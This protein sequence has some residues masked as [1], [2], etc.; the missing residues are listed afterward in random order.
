M[1][2]PGQ[3]GAPGLFT[4]EFTVLTLAAALGFCNIA[5]FYG[6]ATWLERMGV[7]PA[8]RGALIAAEPLAALAARPL[9]SFLLTARR[10]LFTARLG[11]LGMGLAL[12]CYQLAHTAPA[13]FA[14]RVFHGLSFV[15]LVSA[16]MALL[17]KVVPPG[18]AG[19][20]FGYFS[21]SSLI[22]YAVMPP[23]MEWLLP[24]VGGEARAYAWTALLTLPALALMAPLGA[25]LGPGAFPD[26]EDRRG[27]TPGEILENLR[28]GPVLLL[29]GANLLVFCA[30]TQV[31]FFIKPYAV[32][33]RLAEPGLFFTVSTCAS[34]AVRVLG[35]PYFDRLPRRGAALAALAALAACVGLFAW[36]RGA[37]AFFVL[38]GAYGL[39][40]G[41]ALPLLNASL[42]LESAPRF[43][44]ANMN[45]ML[46]MMDAGYVLGPLAG[47]AL[48]AGG[49]GFGALFAAGAACAAAGAAMLAP[50]AAR[51]RRR[52]E[53]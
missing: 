7:D 27:P 28:Q 15:C 38:A 29:L 21:L 2:A 42:F 14:V 6:L 48:V 3:D 41:L 4:Y 23:L 50:L 49:C 19:R 13:L 43:R 25:S 37:A 44:G 12:P 9:L 11:L 36:A 5:V 30:T 47:G 33:L 17:A 35:G 32:S 31:F 51:E 26:E 52:P 18:L 1:S 22:P 46:F 20:A 16:V 10:A 45:L 53:A 39:C 40:L 34:L 8:W 24:R